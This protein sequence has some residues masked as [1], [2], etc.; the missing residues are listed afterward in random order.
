MPRCEGIPDGRCPQQWNDNKVK[1]G[2]GDLMLC[3]DC[4][5]ASAR[6]VMWLAR[7]KP[8]VVSCEPNDVVSKTTPTNVNTVNS[9]VLSQH[10]VDLKVDVEASNKPKATAKK[11]GKSTRSNRSASA[12]SATTTVPS[13][14]DRSSAAVEPDDINSVQ[15]IYNEASGPDALTDAP[16]DARLNMY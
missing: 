12:T 10:V 1:L 2:E 11:H 13:G 4:D 14:C 7:T 16:S 6:H 5:Q 3:A 8:A 9:S 15:Y